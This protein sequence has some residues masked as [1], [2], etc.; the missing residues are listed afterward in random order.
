M[1]TAPLRNGLIAVVA[2]AAALASRASGAATVERVHERITVE[3]DGSARV[4]RTIVP[5]RGPEGPLVTPFGFP[6]P[7]ELTV[8]GCDGATAV[9]DPG[10]GAPR[11][12]VEGAGET[13]MDGPITVRF[14]VPAF[15]DWVGAK[16]A[17]FGNRTIGYRFVNTYPAVIGKYECE[18]ILP[19]GFLVSA[20]EESDPA[21]S[22]RNPAPPFQVIRREGRDGVRLSARDLAIGDDAMIRFRFKS[23]AKPVLL[24]VL[25][26]V[27]IVAYLIGLRGLVGGQT[28]SAGRA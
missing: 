1:R 17:S 20:V 21:P 3:L 25:G 18:L 12:V 7:T 28:G 8:L 4:E 13:Q 22:D 11:L 24:L 5:G 2:L 23:S 9:V 14:T 10:G 27:L 16:S 6:P 15:Y 19:A 26:V